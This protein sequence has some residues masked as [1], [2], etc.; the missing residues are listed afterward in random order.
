VDTPDASGVDH[1]AARHQACADQGIIPECIEL[2]VSIVTTL[3]VKDQVAVLKKMEDIPREVWHRTDKELKLPDGSSAWDEAMLQRMMLP[4]DKN[5]QTFCKLRHTL[6][7]NQWNGIRHLLE[8]HYKCRV[9]RAPSTLRAECVF[10][11]LGDVQPC[12]IAASRLYN[13]VLH[14]CKSAPG[15]ADLTN[16]SPM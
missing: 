16:C 3:H 8:Y 4:L 9:L 12:L 11:A 15:H 10:S 7:N 14:A 5:R 2:P 13:S 6:S 1:S